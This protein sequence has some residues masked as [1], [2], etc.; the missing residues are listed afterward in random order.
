MDD[1]NRALFSKIASIGVAAV[2]APT[3][4]QH[5]QIKVQEFWRALFCKHILLYNADVIHGTVLGYNILK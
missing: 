2:W 4:L 3:I 5:K 1:I